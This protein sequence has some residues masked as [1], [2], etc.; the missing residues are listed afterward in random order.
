M[1]HNRHDLDVLVVGAGMSGIALLWNL[2]DRGFSVLA[3]E[4]CDQ[5]GG[6]W[7]RNRYP[8][9]RCDVESF[10][11]SFGYDDELQQEWVWSMRYPGQR[12]ILGYLQH[13]VERFDLSQHIRLSTRVTAARFDDATN[14]W[15]VE[16]NEGK[17]VVHP[18]FLVMAVGALSAP[19]DIDLPGITEYTG[20]VYRTFDWPHDPEDLAGKRVLVVGTGSSGAQLIPAIAPIVGELYVGQRTPGFVIPARNRD[21]SAEEITAVKRSYTERRKANRANPSGVVRADN[22]TATFEVDEQERRREYEARWEA[23]GLSFLTA[24]SDVMVD[25]H[26][27]AAITDFMRDKIDEIVDDPDVARHL[28]PTGYHL[29]ARRPIVATDYY[30]TFNRPNVTLVDLRVNPISTFTPHGVR[31]ADESEIDLDVVALATGFDAFTGSFST[32]DIRGIDGRTLAEA[33]QHGPVNYLGL[34]VSGFPNMFLMANAGSPSV[35]SN[36]ATAIEQHVDWICAAFEHF[37]DNGVQRAEADPDAQSQWTTTVDTVARMTLFPTDG[38]SSWYQG[39]NIE[40]KASSFMPFAGGLVE[41]ENALLASS[42]EDYAGFTL[43]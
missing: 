18:R 8:G 30:E 4:Q 31:L 26:A 1:S 41:Y 12:E 5:V 14:R 29:G 20:T 9:A 6:T 24:F 23:G 13:V 22:A 17:D 40:G 3:V 19:K 34:A 38:A 10:D 11:Y 37:R 43:S 33:W 39:T 35:L 21:L 36:M 7:Y 16:L 42:G 25:P 28:K 15:T 2:R 27:N 32:V